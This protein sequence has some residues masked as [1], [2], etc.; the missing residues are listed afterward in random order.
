[1][2]GRR[3]EGVPGQLHEAAAR[4]GVRLGAEQP[5]RGGD[6]P[7]GDPRGGAVLGAELLAA[8]ELEQPFDAAAELDR[9]DERGRRADPL[10]RGARRRGQPVDTGFLLPRDGRAGDDVPV[11]LGGERGRRSGDRTRHE[12]A[13]LPGANHD[14]VRAG[15][16]RGSIG[17]RLQRRDQR[18][19][20]S[21]PGR[22][23][24]ERPERVGRPRRPELSD[25]H[26]S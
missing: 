9:D 19:G 6:E 3:G 14:G 24:G 20:G 8:D 16:G 12:P 1:M 11:Q 4:Q 10:G 17:H 15:R 13:A 18:V 2:V 7:G 26:G 21:E 23:R 25:R 22:G 5:Q